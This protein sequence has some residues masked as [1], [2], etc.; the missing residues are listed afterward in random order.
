MSYWHGNDIN[1]EDLIGKT[2]V[3]VDDDGTFYTDTH[4]YEMYHS[5]F[6]CESVY[7][8]SVD[9]NISDITHEVIINAFETGEGGDDDSHSY[10]CVDYTN[11]H[12]VTA[13][14]EVVF[15][16]IGSSNGHY[17]TNVDI[18]EIAHAIM[19]DY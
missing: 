10:E 12:I 14:G 5:Q 18:S 4:K 19:F 8:D 9:G 15:R 6:C 2:F 7:L 11:F 16:W 1:I 3:K 13:K 17:S